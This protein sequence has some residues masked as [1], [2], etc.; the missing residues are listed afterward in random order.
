MQHFYNKDKFFEC[1]TTHNGAN[2]VKN[3]ASRICMAQQKITPYL[4][5]IA[6]LQFYGLHRPI[7]YISRCAT[8]VQPPRVIEL[9]VD[10][11]QKQITKDLHNNKIYTI[12]NVAFND[13]VFITSVCLIYHDQIYRKS[14]GRIKLCTRVQTN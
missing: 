4:V 9:V 13:L 6:R 3:I 14:K 10:S 5:A 2:N 11:R 7:L 8:A 12:T 1:E